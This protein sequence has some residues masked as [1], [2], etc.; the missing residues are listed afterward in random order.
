L[1]VSTNA[2]RGSVRVLAGF[3]GVPVN[4][5]VPWVMVEL[6]QDQLD[7]WLKDPENFVLDSRNGVVDHFGML[8]CD[9]K[10]N[11]SVLSG[12]RAVESCD[13]ALVSERDQTTEFPLP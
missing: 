10:R 4:N 2:A 3:D 13:G 1:S 11:G 9:A 12:C 6:T 5:I 8:R 7:H